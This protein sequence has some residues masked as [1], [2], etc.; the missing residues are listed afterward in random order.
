M[1]GMFKEL[2]VLLSI[3]NA[4]PSWYLE[5]YMWICDDCDVRSL[6]FITKFKDPLEQGS[7]DL[8]NRRNEQWNWYALFVDW[9]IPIITLRD[10]SSFNLKSTLSFKGTILSVQFESDNDNSMTTFDDEKHNVS[11]TNKESIWPYIK[12]K[13]KIDLWYNHKQPFRPILKVIWMKLKNTTVHAA[14][15]C[16]KLYNTFY[17]AS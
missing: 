13:D 11:E 7:R 3:P 1:T 14:W 16:M 4:L 5:I 8:C 9:N 17:R 6:R 15:H 10:T 12:G 2:H